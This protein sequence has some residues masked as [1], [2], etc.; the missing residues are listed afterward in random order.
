[1][2][3]EIWKTILKIASISFIGLEL[4]FICL[5]E[6]IDLYYSVDI[7][8]DEE[9][10][11]FYKNKKIKTFLIMGVNLVLNIILIVFVSI[12]SLTALFYLGIIY[13]ILGIIVLV[14][15]FLDKLSTNAKD[16]RPLDYYEKNIHTVL[17]TFCCLTGFAMICSSFF[18]LAYYKVCKIIEKKKKDE[19]SLLKGY[20]SK[21]S[22]IDLGQNN[23][24]NNTTEENSG[25]FS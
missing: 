19:E 17:V 3:I 7:A 24:A 8:D 6:S 10:H 22:V 15:I 21:D 25:S 23:E 11:S 16:A 1:M 9:A 4:L 13:C 2:K 20:K 14:F 12:S 18:I 5:E